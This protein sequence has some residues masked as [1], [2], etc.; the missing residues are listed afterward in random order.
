M[1][2]SLVWRRRPRNKNCRI[3][4]LQFLLRAKI[5]WCVALPALRVLDEI[6]EIAA[7]TLKSITLATL[8]KTMGW[9][10]QRLAN[11]GD[12]AKE[13]QDAGPAG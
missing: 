3:Y 5:G 6:G 8:L 1:A 12:A 9:H 4:F 7:A 2:N 11:A 13:A 10:E